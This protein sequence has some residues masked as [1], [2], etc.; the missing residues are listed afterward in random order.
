MCVIFSYRGAELYCPSKIK[1]EINRN[2]QE[3]A[4]KAGISEKLFK[5]S[6][7]EAFNNIQLIPKNKFR[8]KIK[9]AK[10]FVK[11]EEDTPFTALALKFKPS[12]IVTYNTDHYRIKKLEKEDVPPS[13]TLERMGLK[14][15][16]ISTEKNGENL[17]S[18]LFGIFKK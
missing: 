10:S 18:K 3:I 17:I 5:V 15:L 8:N 6:I 13:Q 7:K 12:T 1:S 9:K 2:S 4:K 11:D 14:S 16:R